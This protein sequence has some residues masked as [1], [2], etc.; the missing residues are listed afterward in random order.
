MI[1]TGLRKLSNTNVYD[2]HLLKMNIFDI[3]VP[4]INISSSEVLFEQNRMALNQEKFDIEVRNDDAI[5]CNQM[6]FDLMKRTFDRLY[7]LY[8]HEKCPLID[9][10][11]KYQSTKQSAAEF[12]KLN[13]EKNSETNKRRVHLSLLQKNPVL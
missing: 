6:F 8:M 1:H 13:R 4:C 10:I 3:G 5:N 7:G 2:L 9:T 12:E 11:I